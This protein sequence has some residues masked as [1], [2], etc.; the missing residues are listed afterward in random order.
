MREGMKWMKKMASLRLISGNIFT[1]VGDKYANLKAG[2]FRKWVR[3]LDGHAYD[4]RGVG[5]CGMWI[6]D[7]CA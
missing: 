2:S 4:D 3:S 6:V 5:L 1:V 7:R